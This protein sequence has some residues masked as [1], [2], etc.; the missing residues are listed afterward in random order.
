MFIESGREILKNKERWLIVP[1]LMIS[2]RAARNFVPLKRNMESH[3]LNIL[4]AGIGGEIEFSK[5]SSISQ[6]SK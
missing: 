2:R 6:N 5:E 1:K 3:G 4:F